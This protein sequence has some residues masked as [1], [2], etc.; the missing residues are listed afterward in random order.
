[1]VRRGTRNFRL[2]I[3]LLNALAAASFAF[4]QQVNGKEVA[5]GKVPITAPVAFTAND[6][7]DFGSDLGSPV[8]LDYFDAAPF[9]FNGPLG[10]STIKYMK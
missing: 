7:L 3:F 6:C 2:G 10:T 5:S 9:A 1:M 4:A 8:S